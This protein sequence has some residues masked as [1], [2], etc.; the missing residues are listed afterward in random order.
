MCIAD[1]WAALQLDSA[2]TTFG[3]IIENAAQ[4]QIKTGSDDK[5]EWVYKYTL[6]QLLTPGFVIG[7]E[8]DALPIGIDGIMFDEVS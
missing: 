5:P 2:V 7:D 3:R 8:A 1:R 6:A 4:E